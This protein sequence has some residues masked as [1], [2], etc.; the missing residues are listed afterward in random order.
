MRV[1]WCS[2]C[3]GIK[4]FSRFIKH[5]AEVSELFCFGIHTYYLL[6]MFGT[7]I[8][9]TEGNYFYHAGPG[10]IFNNLLPAVTDTYISYL[11]FFVFV[12]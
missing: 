2:N 6:C 5:L 8:Y 11:H 10:K 4:F 3:N 1:V 7:H 9:I 12:F